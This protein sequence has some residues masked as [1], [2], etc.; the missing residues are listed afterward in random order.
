MSLFSRCA[1]RQHEQDMKRMEYQH[2]ERMA[3]IQ[4][5]KE[6][7]LA[8][9]DVEKERQKSIQTFYTNSTSGNRKKM[10]KY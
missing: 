1:K 8:A 7:V 10:L 4:A 9:A 6:C 5:Q 2:K 3:E